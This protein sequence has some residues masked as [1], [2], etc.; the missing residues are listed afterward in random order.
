MDRSLSADP[1]PEPAGCETFG[2]LQSHHQACG[3][4]HRPDD[5]D[6]YRQKRK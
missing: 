4:G 2:P 1:L 5:E 6:R 3:E